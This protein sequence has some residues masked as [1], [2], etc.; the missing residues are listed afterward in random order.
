MENFTHIFSPIKIGTV[1]IPNRIALLGH[2]HRFRA[3]NAVPNDREIRYLE[4]RAKEGV[5]LII[6]G[7][8]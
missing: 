7:P 6:A 8:A 2:N 5:G 1:T 3:R 4:E